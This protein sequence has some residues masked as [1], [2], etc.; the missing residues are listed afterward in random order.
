MFLTVGGSD[1]HSGL[2]YFGVGHLGGYGALPDE[3]VEATLLRSSFDI[4]VGYVGGTYG[5]VCLLRSL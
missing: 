1:V 2:L 3:I 5:F 4:V